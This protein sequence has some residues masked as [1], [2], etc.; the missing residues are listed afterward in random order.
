MAFVIRNAQGDY[1][2]NDNGW[3]EHKSWA[4]FFDDDSEINDPI[5]AVRREGVLDCTAGF[6]GL[7]QLVQD[8][9]GDE[10]GWAMS[11]WFAI[12]DEM[13]FNRDLAT[14]CEWQFHP[15]PMG[16]RNDDEWKDE[17]LA[18]MSNG[19]LAYLGKLLHRYT[20]RLRKLGKDY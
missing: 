10:W 1:W 17:I 5:K 13:T 20:T 15:S 18:Q 4:T 7:Q 14:P 6:Y 19:Q 16:K 12:C 8:F 11:W 9:D 2:S 3:T